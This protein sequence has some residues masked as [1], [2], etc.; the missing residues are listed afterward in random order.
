MNFHGEVK[1]EYRLYASKHIYCPSGGKPTDGLSPLDHFAHSS[2]LVPRLWPGMTSKYL[3]A[4]QRQQPSLAP[5]FSLCHGESL[6]FADIA[7]ARTL[8]HPPFT[9]SY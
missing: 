5:P 2:H 8:F 1:C 7:R 4:A 3:H 6:D 9:F